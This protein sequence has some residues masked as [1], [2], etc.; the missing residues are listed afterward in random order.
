ML[1]AVG[2]TDFIP[3]VLWSFLL[4]IFISA[5]YDVFRIR[6]FALRKTEA[7][8]RLFK[9]LSLV[10]AVLCFFEDILII[11]FSAVCVILLS[12]KLSRGI[13]RWYGIFAVLI[14]F[15]LYHVTLG[16]IVM[17]SASKILGAI[18]ALI[19]LMLRYTVKPLKKPIILLTERV[20]GKLQEKQTQK[21]EK[22]VLKEIEKTLGEPS[23]T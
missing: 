23:Q 2:K 14:G 10:D 12:F 18:S 22:S 19:K 16:R 21:Y 8:A 6:R 1:V 9:R 13:P 20:K 15:T 4:G 7:A 11:L 17:L 5:I 3:Y